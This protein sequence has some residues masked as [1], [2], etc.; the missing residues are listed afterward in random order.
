[1]KEK[2]TTI[3]STTINNNKLSKINYFVN[4]K[5]GSGFRKIWKNWRRQ[6]IPRRVICRW[7]VERWTAR[8][9]RCFLS[10]LS[11]SSFLT[12]FSSTEVQN[13]VLDEKRHGAKNLSWM[14]LNLLIQS[15]RSADAGT[16]EASVAAAAA[17][18]AATS[19]WT[20]GRARRLPRPEA[21]LPRCFPA[22]LCRLVRIEDTFF[23]YVSLHKFRH[24]ISGKEDP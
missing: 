20:C 23:F 24:T 18:A 12:F 10:T 2:K 1:M 8:R 17:A 3:R 15:T 9:R 16:H 19:P 7:M 13:K 5:E 11:P 21:G 14:A 22:S 6:E 4:P